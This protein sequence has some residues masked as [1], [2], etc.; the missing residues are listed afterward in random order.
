MLE[1]ILVTFKLTAVETKYTVPT[2]DET[3]YFWPCNYSSGGSLYSSAIDATLPTPESK[4]TSNK[5]MNSNERLHREPTKNSATQC[6]SSC[7]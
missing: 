3:M 1:F 4:N 7:G 5:Q 6:S 2:K